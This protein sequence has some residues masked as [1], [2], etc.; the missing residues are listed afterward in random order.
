MLR[1]GLC[2]LL[3][4]D[5][6]IVQAPM[7]PDLSGPELVATVSEAGGLGVLQAQLHPPPLLREQIRQIR[8]LTGRPFAVDF[9][10]HH[11]SDDGIAVCL[12][13]GVPLLSFFWGDPTPH[14]ERAHR[15][16]ARVLHQVGSVAA[17]RRA[18][19]AGVDVI[20]AQGFEAGGHVAGEVTTMAL[21]PRVVDAVAPTPV[22]AAGGIA[23]GR[24][25]LAALALGAEAAVLGTR[26]LVTTESRAHPAYKQKLIEA[27]EEDTVHTTLFGWGWPHAPHRTLRTAFVEEW[28]G[29]EGRGQESR[30]DEPVVGHT[31]IGGQ[32]MP[33]LRFMGFPPNRDASGD[34]EAMDL[35]AGQGVGLV[36][37]VRPAGEVIRA[38]A[39]D[40]ERRLRE[41]L[42]PLCDAREQ[43]A[44]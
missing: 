6:P 36:A 9:I 13:E 40:A 18:A 28:R 41:R 20:V 16:G 22:A 14:V 1:T 43:V 17:A 25:L 29:K 27:T 4:I 42:A 12:D 11:P 35:L 30:P 19:D 38:I 5:L 8:S 23:D 31:R 32:E 26:L 10:L 3:G 21:V 44:G 33:L 39:A 34:I 2:G 15:A 37:D 24:G 7:G